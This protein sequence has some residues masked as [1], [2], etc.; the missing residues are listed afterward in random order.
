MELFSDN[1]IDE[2]EGKIEKLITTY[3]SVKEEKEKLISKVQAL[4]TENK[5]LKEKM[6][7]SKTE[8]ELIASKITKIL[9]KL[10]K[11]EV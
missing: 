11:A 5:E 9:E 1:R 10:D 4:E 6:G 3:K 2:L 8:K 7:G